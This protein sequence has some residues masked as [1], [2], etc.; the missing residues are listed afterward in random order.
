VG[1]P[2]R[3]AKDPVEAADRIVEEIALGLADRG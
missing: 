2:I 1:R 3:L